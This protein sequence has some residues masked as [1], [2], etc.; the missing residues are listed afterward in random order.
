M[1]SQQPRQ[2][3]VSFAE[4]SEYEVHFLSPRPSLQPDLGQEMPLAADGMWQAGAYGMPTPNNGAP[5]F[6]LYDLPMQTAFPSFS[7]PPTPLLAPAE[8]P[9]TPPPVFGGLRPA[10]PLPSGT[11][12]TAPTLGAEDFPLP[13]RGDLSLPIV[14]R[15]EQRWNVRAS[16]L[17]IDLP[18]DEPVQALCGVSEV[19]LRFTPHA[20]FAPF[21]HT[22]AVAPN[23]EGKLVVTVGDLAR[24]IQAALRARVEG[25]FSDEQRNALAEAQRHRRLERP[26]VDCRVDMWGPGGMYLRHLVSLNSAGEGQRR[27]FAVQFQLIVSSF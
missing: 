12:S 19:V 22:I 10:L 17:P 13:P 23:Y 27:V 7:I 2:R 6:V 3:R 24:S 5:H 4:E 21:S 20:L 8:L 11:I 26:P 25:R 1:T 14:W 15:L 9:P 16:G 18:E